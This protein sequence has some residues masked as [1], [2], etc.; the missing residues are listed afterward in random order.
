ML[1]LPFSLH[2][3]VYELIGL[4]WDVLP[5][6]PS[7][8]YYLF[9]CLYIITIPRGP[10]MLDRFL[11]SS[12]SLYIISYITFWF[13]QPIKLYAFLLPLILSYVIWF[14]YAIKWFIR[15]LPSNV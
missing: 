13:N 3:R 12:R 2:F 1:L 4:F 11:L 8:I 5:A 15:R 9:S 14:I 6:F 7:A 10:W